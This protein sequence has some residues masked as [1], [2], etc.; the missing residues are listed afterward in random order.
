[1]IGTTGRGRDAA[2]G[3]QNATDSTDYTDFL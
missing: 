1:M 3:K 2:D